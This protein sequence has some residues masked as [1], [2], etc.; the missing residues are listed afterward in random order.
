[1][2]VRVRSRP[3]PSDSTPPVEAGPQRDDRATATAQAISVGRCAPVCPMWSE[4]HRHR[5]QGARSDR[6][7]PRPPGSRRQSA[8]A[9]EG[10]ATAVLGRGVAANPAGPTARRFVEPFWMRVLRSPM[11]PDGDDRQ[12]R[13]GRRGAGGGRLASTRRADGVEP[14][15]AGADERGRRGF[16]DA[17]AGSKCLCSRGTRD[18]TDDTGPAAKMAGQLNIQAVLGESVVRID[19]VRITQYAQ[20]EYKRDITGATSRSAQQLCTLWSMKSGRG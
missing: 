16:G 14:G 17:G 12:V 19:M 7:D 4:T 9:G 1:M 20:V 6:E 2:A 3:A 15:S 13:R 18:A 11:W 5:G 8:D 10:P